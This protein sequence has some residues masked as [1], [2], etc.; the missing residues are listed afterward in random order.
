MPV[1]DLVKSDQ[2]KTLFIKAYI[3][4]ICRLKIKLYL[5]KTHPILNLSNWLIMCLFVFCSYT[6][7]NTFSQKCL[8]TKYRLPHY[9]Y[10]KY[11]S[12]KFIWP[13]SNCQCTPI[14]SIY[15]TWFR[16]NYVEVTLLTPMPFDTLPA[17][18]V[19]FF[20]WRPRIF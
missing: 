9:T 5:R 16:L 13:W 8:L 19:N 6:V 3:S 7:L 17:Q 20:L 2:N 1:F 12:F 11:T 15:K 4:A 18:L 14:L 10:Y